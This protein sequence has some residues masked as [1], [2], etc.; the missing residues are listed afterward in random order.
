MLLGPADSALFLL[1][2]SFLESLDLVAMS[3]VLSQTPEHMWLCLWG[4]ALIALAWRFR[5]HPHRRH[6]E[7]SATRHLAHVD[8]RW[9]HQAAH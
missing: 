9:S 4:F 6:P 3:D 8:A 1:L 2:G 5:A 7:R